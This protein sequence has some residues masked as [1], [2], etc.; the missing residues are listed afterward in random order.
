MVRTGLHIGMDM[1]VVD[2]A[3]LAKRTMRLPFVRDLAACHDTVGL[4]L[5]NICAP[6]GT[7]RS[8]ASAVSVP[9]PKRRKPIAAL[10]L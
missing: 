9:V 6:E 1:R 4:T 2:N 10:A 3:E 7:G 5:N 8:V